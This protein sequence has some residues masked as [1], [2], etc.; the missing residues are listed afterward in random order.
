MPIPLVQDG[1][2]S[3][4]DTAMQ[5]RAIKVIQPLIPADA[6]E[7][8][9]RSLKQWN[10]IVREH[11]RNETGLRLAD[12][13]GRN[14]I[15]VRVADGFPV[16]LA[17]LINSY[18]DPVLWRIIVG[19]PKLGGIIDGLKFLLDDWASFEKW[20]L[21]PEIAKGGEATLQR[22]GDIAFALQK[23]A[24]AEEVRKRIRQIDKDILGVYRFMPGLASQIEL[25][26]MAVAM[27]AAMLDLR[28]EDLTV[29]V[30]AHELAHG[31]THIG[32]D[33]DGVQ[34]S[35]QGFKESDL[36]VIEGLAQFYTEVVT[37][38]MSVRI[39]GPHLAYRKLLDLQ[40]G[41]Y[42]AH[43]EWVKNDPNQK[44]ETIRFAMIAARSQG[45]TELSA[46]TQMLSSTRTSLRKRTAMGMTQAAK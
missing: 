34:W 20:P 30:L 13:D 10:L 17:E 16:P 43:L 24:V 28:I 46:W 40:T 29:V 9:E 37:N 14:S 8:V 26:W 22:T 21:L 33:I 4:V 6:Q 5:D 1:K 11:I 27:V 7:R 15:Q 42:Q 19:Q 35:D 38:R 2:E 45:K 39:P 41:P 44:G 32:R 3:P 25:Y 12:G 36:H 18:R 31:Y 23:L